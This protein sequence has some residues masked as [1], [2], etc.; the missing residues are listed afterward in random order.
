MFICL[1]FE[2][3][4]TKENP[5]SFVITQATNIPVHDAPCEADRKSVISR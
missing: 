2:M 4:N 5:F 3:V 1:F